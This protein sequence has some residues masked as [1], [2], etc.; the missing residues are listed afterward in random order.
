MNDLIG[1]ISSTKNIEI[2]LDEL[3]A[4]ITNGDLKPCNSE[5]FL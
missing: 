4:D 3:I 5:G 2:I 1:N